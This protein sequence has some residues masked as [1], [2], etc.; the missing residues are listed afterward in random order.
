MDS[1]TLWVRLTFTPVQ[2]V[3]PSPFKWDLIDVHRAVC[4]APKEGPTSL[5][6]TSIC[7]TEVTHREGAEEGTARLCSNIPGA[8]VA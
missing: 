5:E 4:G 2:W 3:T 6:S 1:L 7:I 8:S